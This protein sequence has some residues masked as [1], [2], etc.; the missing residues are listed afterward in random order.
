M[1]LSLVP[2][3][4]EFYDL[5]AAA[6]QNALDTARLVEARFKSFPEREVRQAEVKEL[7][8]KGDDLTR[9]TIELLNTQYITPF[10]REDIYE[11]AKAIDDVVDFIENASDLLTLYKVDRV[12]AEALEQCRLLVEAAENLAKAL[13][14][15]RGLR[16]TERYLIEVKRL[17]DEADQLLRG[18]IAGLFENHVDPVE[19]IRW[20]DIFDALED[21]IDACET[22]SDVVGNIVVKNL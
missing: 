10:D 22:A 7:E 16:N 20:K 12:A 15:L 13:A 2:R 4:T 1:K 21:A 18:A 3:T 11:L 17:E 14:E 9:Q 8:N 6:G 5:F 19:V